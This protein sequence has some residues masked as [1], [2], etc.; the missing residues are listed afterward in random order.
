MPAPKKW[1]KK[2]LLAKIEP[3]YGTDAVPLPATDAIQGIDV[4]W[5]P[6]EG[7]DVNR[8]ELD[9]LDQDAPS[10]GDARH[11]GRDAGGSAGGGG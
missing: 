9:E 3:T 10:R 8:L 6:M 7:S 5:T 4:Q 2:V 1:R 11:L